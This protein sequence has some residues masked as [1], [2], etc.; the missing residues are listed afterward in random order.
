VLQFPKEKPDM[1]DQDA[2]IQ[3]LSQY[4]IDEIV[5]AAG[6]KKTARTRRVFDFFLHRVTMY[7]S[8]ICVTTDRK[9]ATDGFP[10][11]VG[12]MAGHWVREIHTRGGATIPRAAPDRFKPCRGL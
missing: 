5:N 6:L 8:T 3:A 9:I 7:L 12:W 11:A 10:S 2:E 1:R 4:L